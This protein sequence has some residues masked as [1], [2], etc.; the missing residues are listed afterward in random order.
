MRDDRSNQRL[1]GNFAAFR[2]DREPKVAKNFEG[3]NPGFDRA[4]FIAEQAGF[5]A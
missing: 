2:V 5:L 1:G 3:I 4:G